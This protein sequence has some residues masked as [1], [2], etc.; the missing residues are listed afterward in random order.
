ML[1][2]L[3]HLDTSKMATLVSSYLGGTG[4]GHNPAPD[5][6]SIKDPGHLVALKLHQA[7]NKASPCLPCKSECQRNPCYHEVDS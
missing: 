5:E 1:L 3:S 7:D 4:K 2:E 6:R